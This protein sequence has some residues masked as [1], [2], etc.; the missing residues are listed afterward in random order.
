MVL[1]WAIQRLNGVCTPASASSTAEDL[2]HQLRDS[3]AKAVF[4]CEPLLPIALKAAA[5]VGIPESHVYLIDLPGQTRTST[6]PSSGRKSLQDLVIEGRE[7]P[8]LDALSWEPGQ[9]A[10]QVAFLC[11]SSGTSGR[12][13][14]SPPKRLHL[15]SRG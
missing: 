9:G 6:D 10:R 1:T 3:Q 8:A 5:A 13:V 11:Y 7:E 14:I 4:T 12:P 15:K 2:E